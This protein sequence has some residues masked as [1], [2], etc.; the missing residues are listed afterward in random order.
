MF[1]GSRT[2][3]AHARGCRQREGLEDRVIDVA[4]HVAKSPRAEVEALAPVAGVI[5]LIPDKLAV[6]TDTQPEIP[7]KSVRHRILAIRHLASIAPRLV[8]PGVHF[9]DLSD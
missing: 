1:V 2:F 8:A 5:P 4:A 9:L 6:L 3:A 7:V